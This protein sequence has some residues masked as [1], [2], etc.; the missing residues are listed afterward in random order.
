MLPTRSPHLKHRGGVASSALSLRRPN[1]K[2]D[3]PGSVKC[4]NGLGHLPRQGRK[5]RE[6]GNELS[7]SPCR[8]RTKTKSEIILASSAGI[9]LRKQQQL[10]RSI[11]RKILPWV[12]NSTSHIAMAPHNIF[13]HSRERHIYVSTPNALKCTAAG[14]I[15]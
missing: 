6:N 14:A 13:I 12:L 3:R 4:V 2:Q 7:L 10:H 8:S 9:V 11:S 5:R 15:K 1:S